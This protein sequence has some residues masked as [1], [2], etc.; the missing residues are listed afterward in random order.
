MGVILSIERRALEQWQIASTETLYEIKKVVFF[1]LV[2]LYESLLY[3]FLFLAAKNQDDMLA[4]FAKKEGEKLH[5]DLP[6]GER[7]STIEQTL[8]KIETEI[9]FEVSRQ[10]QFES[11]LRGYP[12]KV[13]NFLLIILHHS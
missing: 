8:S 9:D 11:D 12:T 1:I 10:K 7:K 3:Y 2:I 13:Q 4:V 6:E 5:R